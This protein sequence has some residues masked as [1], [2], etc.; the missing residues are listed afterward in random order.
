MTKQEAFTIVSQ[1]CALVQAVLAAH[2]K[3]QE[4]L[5]ILQPKEEGKDAAPASNS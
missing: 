1:A 3:I 4:A 2:Q 5:S